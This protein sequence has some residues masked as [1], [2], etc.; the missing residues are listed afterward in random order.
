MKLCPITL[1][2]EPHFFAQHALNLGARLDET[3]NITGL[4]QMPFQDVLRLKR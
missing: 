1:T 4:A 2:N 3:L